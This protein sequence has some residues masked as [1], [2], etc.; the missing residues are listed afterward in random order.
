[1]SKRFRAFG[2]D[3]GWVN[4]K[5]LA[6]VENLIIMHGQLTAFGVDKKG[7]PAAE[8]ISLPKTKNPPR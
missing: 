7:K 3:G 8:I 6:R 1:M 2:A 5:K 4:L